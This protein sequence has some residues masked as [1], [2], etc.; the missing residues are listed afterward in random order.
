LVDD[1]N[2]IGSA[3]S[4]ATARKGDVTAVHQGEFCLV[5]RKRRRFVAI[6]NP[7]TRGNPALITKLLRKS[8]PLDVDLDIRLSPA[9]GSTTSLARSARTDAFAV[10]AVGGDGTVGAVATALQGTSIPMGI[11]PVGTTN[12]IANELGIPSNPASAIELS[13]NSN[14][15][16]LL[17]M[18]SNDDLGFLHMAGAGIDSR[19]FIGANSTLKKRLGW[20]AYVPAALRTLR[21]PPA[22]VTVVSD[23]DT[24]EAASPLVLVANGRS[25]A[26]GVRLHPEIHSD[27]GWLDVVLFTSTTLIPMLG[28]FGNLALRRLVDSPH[29]VHRRAKRVEISSNPLLPVE[30]DGDIRTTTPVTFTVSPA[31]LSVIV[32]ANC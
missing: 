26:P 10:I 13:F 29:L 22:N 18:G 32:A 23:G 6:I 25:I 21:Y 8:A 20:L 14:H 19:M 12:L 7:A 3:E 4:T 17:D 1:K 28:T 15:T 16:V 2:P 11:V 27:D 9:D 24:F 31:S 5:Y 30:L